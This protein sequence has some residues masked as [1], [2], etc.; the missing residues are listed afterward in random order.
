MKSLVGR[1]VTVYL[2][3]EVPPLRLEGR[4]DD[5]RDGVLEVR[6]ARRELHSLKQV[7]RR[8]LRV[9]LEYVE[10]REVWGLPCRLENFATAFPPVLAL[11]PSGSPRLVHR[12]RHERYTTNLPARLI[13]DSTEH[14]KDV[15]AARDAWEDGRLVNL[16]QGGAAACLPRTLEQTLPRAFAPGSELFLQFVASE[17]VKPK[18][19]VVRQEE[20]PDALV[21]GLEFV[22]LNSHDAATLNTYLR[23]LSES[24][25]IE[26]LR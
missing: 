12:R 8:T 10:G 3:E 9:E 20:G 17:L 26:A 15:A 13:Y 2:A 18:V 7:L 14:R 11:H 4:I 24:A 21:L 19:R 23:Q 16:S 22:T 6:L 5:S 25:K 1:A